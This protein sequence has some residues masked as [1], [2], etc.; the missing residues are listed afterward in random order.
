MFS[1]LNSWALPQACLSFPTSDCNCTSLIC[2]VTFWGLSQGLARGYT[3]VLCQSCA[4][5]PWH[6][7]SWAPQGGRLQSQGEEHCTA[8]VMVWVFWERQ[9]SLQ[10]PAL[11]L[12]SHRR[13]LLQFLLTWGWQGSA[14]SH[15]PSLLLLLRSYMTHKTS[16]CWVKFEHKFFFKLLKGIP[17]LCS[18]CYS[19]FWAWVS[20]S[21]LS[22]GKCTHS[23]I[24]SL[25]LPWSTSRQWAVRDL[26]S[27]DPLSK[28]EW[29]CEVSTGIA[30]IFKGCQHFSWMSSSADWSQISER[31]PV[32]W[33]TGSIFHRRQIEFCA[34]FFLKRRHTQSQ[35][36]TAEVAAS[37]LP[38]WENAP[39]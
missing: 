33:N 15:H 11:L 27:P 17:F 32:P 5:G 7:G 24:F 12:R 9:P 28:L 8:C 1:L 31:A 13:A 38:Q 30:W 23:L 34:S 16:V 36:H 25:L 3:A 39:E 6:T 14:H 2:A 22:I 18:M 10:N 21:L 20:S 29:W 26:I 35:T 19:Q 4:L 37:V